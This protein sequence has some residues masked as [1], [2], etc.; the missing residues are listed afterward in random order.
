MREK[1][2]SQLYTGLRSFI[3]DLFKFLRVVRD[4]NFGKHPSN[5]NDGIADRDGTT[6]I[7]CG[8]EEGR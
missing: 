4:E 7:T 2:W 1:A 8:K 6:K 3:L 5:E